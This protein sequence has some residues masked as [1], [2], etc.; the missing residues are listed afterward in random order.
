MTSERP[1]LNTGPYPP[2]EAISEL[3]GL[4]E[5]KF[6]T[7]LVEQFIQTVGLYPIGS[8]VEL[9][10]GQVGAVVETNGLRRLKPS[11]ML[12]LNEKKEPYSEFEFLDLSN[13]SEVV[14]VKSGLPPGA[15]GINMQEIFL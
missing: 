13:T 15:Y 11:V 6:H 10:T 1:Y 7:E 5:S 9:S 12:L 14:E 8:L 3:Y 2:H 4:K